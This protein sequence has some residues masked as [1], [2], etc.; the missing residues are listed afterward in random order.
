MANVM[1]TFNV[2]ITKK[3]RQQLEDSIDYI[4][5]TLKNPQAAQSV[6]HDAVETTNRLSCLAGSLRFCSNPIL[7][8]LGYHI[9]SFKYHKYIMIYHID[10]QNAYVDALYHQLQDYENN[11]SDDLD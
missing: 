5:N 3:A 6:W 10:G 1:D 11:F 2:I 8:S 4:H 9:I 7:K